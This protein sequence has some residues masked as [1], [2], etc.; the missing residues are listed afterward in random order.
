MAKFN[1]NL[2]NPQTDIK[3]ESLQT[4]TPV[5]FIIRWN[6]KKLVYPTELSIVPKHWQNDKTKGNK[7]QRAKSTLREHAEFNSTL[8]NL[9]ATARETY[10][11]LVNELKRQPNPKELKDGI[12]LA[13]N[14]Q[15]TERM[16]FF[17]FFDKFIEQSKFRINEHTN[18]RFSNST[19]SIYKNALKHLKEYKKAKQKNI[20]FDTID[21]DFYFD[22]NKYLTEEKKFSEN[23]KVK[24]I[25]VIK[26]V[27]NDATERGINKNLAYKSKTFKVVSEDVENIYLDENE[28][29]ELYSLDLSSNPRLEKVRDLFY[30]GC[31]TGLRF[32]DLSKVKKENI[33]GNRLR[34]KTQK[35]S[36]RVS[37]HLRPEAV[38]I[39]NK[40]GGVFPP[41]ISN[42]KMNEYIKE[43][44]SEVT[45]LK[46]KIEITRFKEGLNYTENIEK[47]KL[48]TT[49]TARRSFATN[50]YYMK[51][52]INTIM[53]ITGHKKESSFLKYLKLDGDDHAD[54]YEMYLNKNN[55]QLKLA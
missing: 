1:F 14:R 46:D 34:V 29:K 38:E 43:I 32:S 25:K 41:A 31:V 16:D 33:D 12:D 21:L 5:N 13:L 11:R 2:R 53:A 6:N 20:D 45:C 35:T 49:H 23:N 15:Q 54:I 24:L 7:Y 36:K 3:K 47:Y 48:V 55:S 18:K 9:T 40:Y 27:L 42:Q 44:C 52:P 50:S 37:I 4:P 17:T 39:I 8:D 26:T 19:I 10:N 51:I 30:I 22:Y 28:L